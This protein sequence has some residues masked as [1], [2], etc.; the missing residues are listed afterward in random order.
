M[1]KISS[2]LSKFLLFLSKTD[3]DILKSCPQSTR[4]QQTALGAFVLFTGILAFFSASF[5]ASNL[6]LEI[7]EG[8]NIPEVT[9]KGLYIAALIGL[10]YACM[11]M[12]IDREIVSTTNKWSATLRIPLALIIGVVIAVPLELK[13]MEPNIM[14][15]LND[16]AYKKYQGRKSEIITS[17]ELKYEKIDSIYTKS[18]QVYLEDMRNADLRMLKEIAGDGDAKAGPGQIW[19]AAKRLRNIAEMRADSVSKLRDKALE[20]REKE[21]EDAKRAFADNPPVTSYDFLSMYRALQEMKEKDS[22][23]AVRN[24]S[25]GIMLLLVFLELIPSLMKLLSSKSEYDALLEARRRLNIQLAHRVVN[26]EMRTLEDENDENIRS[27]DFKKKIQN[28]FG[29]VKASI[30][31]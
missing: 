17:V 29:S 8:I 24:M 11:I 20:G 7:P 21:I 25:W 13:L 27:E 6:F 31:R 1:E 10:L 4:Y 19:L 12:A 22:T 30:M 3:T 14:E 2:F 23:N 9:Q 18:M 15:Y 26:T 28:S 5:A 16:N